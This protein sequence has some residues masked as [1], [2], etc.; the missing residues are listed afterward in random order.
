MNVGE[1]YQYHHVPNFCLHKKHQQKSWKMQSADPY[2]AMELSVLFNTNSYII[3]P[4]TTWLQNISRN[5]VDVYLT[6]I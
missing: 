4:V 3:L 2:E 5:S 1:R 6:E